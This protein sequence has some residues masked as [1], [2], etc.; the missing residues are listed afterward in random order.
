MLYNHTSDI[1]AT[2]IQSIL[3]L[4]PQFRINLSIQVLYLPLVPLP[5]SILSQADLLGQSS[6]ISC[7]LFACIVF[8]TRAKGDEL[9]IRF[10]SFFSRRDSP[11]S[12]YFAN[13]LSILGP[14]KF[15][16]KLKSGL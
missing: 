8:I 5:V 10:C 2:V 1:S 16:H 6:N 4:Q 11:L 15:P 14:S 12:Y 7:T 13:E 9:R 3:A